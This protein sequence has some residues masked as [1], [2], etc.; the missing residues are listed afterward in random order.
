ML[1]F[2]LEEHGGDGMSPT[3]GLTESAEMFWYRYL[4]QNRF[5]ARVLRVSLATGL[6]FSAAY[7]VIRALGAPQ[8]PLRGRLLGSWNGPITFSSV[9]AM[10]FLI[11]FV[12]DATI[13]CIVLLRALRWQ[14]PEERGELDA[15]GK[16]TSVARWPQSTIDYY[17]SQMNVDKSFLDDWITL[18]FVAKRT[19]AVAGLVYLPFVV[20]ALMI[21]SRSSIFDRWGTNTGLLVVH[22]ASVVI[23]IGCGI[24]LRQSAEDLR[25][26]A[27]RRL[28][29]RRIGLLGQDD[30]ARRTAGQV[31]LMITQIKAIDTGAFAPYSQ[32]P[33]VR[34]LLLP[35]SSYG[36]AALVEYLSIAGF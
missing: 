13:F 17:A 8:S 33:I 2:R 31:D 26:R 11:F 3:T 7:L 32:Q 23:V 14:L 21:A 28:S 19:R 9:L 35:L 10:L 22:T 25:R 4:Y 36:G 18:Q 6:Y 29:E 20:I 15:T 34:A 30:A 5:W 12:V 1:S 16:E 24:M 27:I